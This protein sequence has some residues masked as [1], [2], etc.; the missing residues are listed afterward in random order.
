MG[1]EW[2]CLAP[3]CGY[4]DVHPFTCLCGAGWRSDGP[5]HSLDCPCWSPLHDNPDNDRDYDD[6]DDD[7]RDDD[8]DWRDAI[9]VRPA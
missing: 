1:G 3:G 5:T 4:I 9:N 7:W 6:R 8:D 2:V